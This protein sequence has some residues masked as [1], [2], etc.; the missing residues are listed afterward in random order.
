M[1]NKVMAAKKIA[2]C[3]KGGKMGCKETGG[4]LD[5]LPAVAGAV[6]P[7]LGTAL[8]VVMN[9]F[10]KEEEVK[11]IENIGYSYKK[12]G[13]LTQ[14]NAPSHAKG[15][16]KIDINGNPSK[17]PIA[18]IEKKENIYTI[19]GSK[20]KFVFSDFLTNDETGNTFAKDA[21]VMTK[22]LKGKDDLTQKTI[23]KV[24]SGL[25]GKNQRKID[26]D[27][28]VKMYNGGPLKDPMKTSSTLED[29]PTQSV[30]PS[31][32][33]YVPPFLPSLT[34]PLIVP[35]PN[36]NM[37]MNFRVPGSDS[38]STPDD[39]PKEKTPNAGINPNVF[40][41]ILKGTSLMGT[42]ADAVAGS[43]K[44]KLQIP[45]FQKGDNYMNKMNV[46]FNPVLSE[47][48]RGTQAA[49]ET[50]R[51]YA[52][53]AGQLTNR[54]GSAFAKAAQAAAEAKMQQQGQV[55]QLLGSKAGREDNKAGI[56][57]NEKIRQQTAQSQNDAT[58]RLAGRKLFQDLSQIGTTINQVKYLK[59]EAKNNNEL[60]N[61]NAAALAKMLNASFDEFGL[62][63]DENKPIKDFT[64]KDWQNLEVILKKIGRTL[65]L[66]SKRKK[67]N[68]G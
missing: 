27:D 30:D 38:Y 5:A 13:K 16:M 40:A 20:E 41:A 45:D 14:Y 52:Q 68:N 26:M 55:N 35:T 10:N 2:S 61:M 22:N 37:D 1:K 44:E 47:I 12:G 4:I 51:D 54:A 46:N 42:V 23:D 58:S 66:Y 43:E 56:I 57:A 18:E 49:I 33:N 29:A 6:N 50:N 11:P 32:P 8:D 15:G 67:D 34:K 21:K 3:R 28:S 64:E 24:L 25:M 17:K 9:M 53:S 36:L 59:D 62:N 7:I 19:P 31:L 65:S 60:A 48:Q 63:I 39:A